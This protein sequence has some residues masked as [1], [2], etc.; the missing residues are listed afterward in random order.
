MVLLYRGTDKLP[1]T[2][3]V[4]VAGSY[5]SASFR[6]LL[7]VGQLLAGPEASSTFPLARSVV[8]ALLRARWSDPVAAQE[9]L[10][11]S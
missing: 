9:L 11:G 8:V 2:V 1:V 3:Q 7:G 6:P 5:S 4:P 10:A